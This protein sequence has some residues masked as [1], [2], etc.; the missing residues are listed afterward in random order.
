MPSSS[1]SKSLGLTLELPPWFRRDDA[2]AFWGRDPRSLSERVTLFE[3]GE[4]RIEWVL[5]AG[6][7]GEDLSPAGPCLLWI[8][9]PPGTEGVARGGL[10]TPGTLQD[11][12]RD[13]A[14]SRAVALLVRLLGLNVDPRP[15]ERSLAAGPHAA[16]V[17]RPGLTIPQTPSVFDGVVW[18]IAGQLVSLP[19]AFLV[20][21]RLTDRFG[22]ELP[23]V[24][25]GGTHKAS[26]GAADLAAASLGELRA[27]SLTARKAEY[28]SAIARAVDSGELDLE[29][30]ASRPAEEVAAQLGAMRGLGPWSVGYLMMRSLGFA[31]CVPVGDVALAKSLCEY[32]G[33]EKRP[34]RG[35]TEAL[36]AP[37]APW[38]SL[39]SFHFWKLLEVG[40]GP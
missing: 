17:R 27:C 38:R 28:L 15:F 32:F 3:S 7:L 31:D 35:E 33:L 5:R 20:R 2:L 29:G 39:A 18:V 13:L 14:S 36:M 23:G 34:G 22:A 16:L 8:D 12:S 26:P 9:L 30:M 24:G 11:E 10:D 19:V 40:E 37:F 6:V 1:T 4:G 25:P 21:R